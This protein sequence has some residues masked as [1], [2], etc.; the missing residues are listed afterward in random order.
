MFGLSSRFFL[1]SLTRLP[2]YHA[3]FKPYFMNLSVFESRAFSVKNVP[4]IDRNSK[5]QNVPIKLNSKV[6]NVSEK[7][8]SEDQ[9]VSQKVNSKEQIS[10]VCF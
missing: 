2:R 1:Y 10:N 6:Q 9:S 7:Q 5:G 4:E 3:L 8:N